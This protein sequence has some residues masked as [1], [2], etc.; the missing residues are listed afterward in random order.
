MQKVALLHRLDGV[1]II[2]THLLWPLAGMDGMSF[3][4]Q[5]VPSTA[6]EA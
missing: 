5:E 3:L 2:L 1:C 4:P 6:L